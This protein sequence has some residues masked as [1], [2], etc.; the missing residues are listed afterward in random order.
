[1]HGRRRALNNL[2]PRRNRSNTKG[3]EPRGIELDAEG[4]RRQQAAHAGNPA[5]NS[6]FNVCPLLVKPKRRQN[7]CVTYRRTRI[8]VLAARDHR[9]RMATGL[10]SIAIGEDL[11]EFRSEEKDL[12][13]I[14]DPDDEYDNGSSGFH[15]STQCWLSPDIAVPVSRVS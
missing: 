13:R 1:M 11:G 14:I 9:R 8:R 15:S 12:T 6:G 4:R 10:R 2:H 5:H 3:I 7:P